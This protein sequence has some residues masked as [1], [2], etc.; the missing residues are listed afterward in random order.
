MFKKKIT[1][2][3]KLNAVH[4]Y[5][6]GKA[7]Q[8]DIAEQYGISTTSVQQWIRNFES[9]GADAFFMPNYKKYSLE[10]KTTAVEEYL[11]GKGSQ[12]DVCKKYG[13]RSKGKL[14]LWIKMYNGHEELKASPTGGSKIMTKGRKTTYEERIEIVEYC[15]E[16]NNNYAE[17]AEKYNVSYQQVYTWMRKYAD[18]GVE[19]LVDRRGRT[20]PKEEMTELEQLRLEQRMLQA[21]IK[22]QEMEIAL[23]KKLEELERGWD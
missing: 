7:S 10:L 15:I 20:K 14:Q 13:I 2:E 19:G 5:L 8:R 21:K 3:E 9:M 16:H 1:C 11:S 4:Q 23:L 6:D 22:R 12:D 17:T 18:K